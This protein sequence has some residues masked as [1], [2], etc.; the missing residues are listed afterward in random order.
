VFRCRRGRAFTVA[1]DAGLAARETPDEAERSKNEA[2][3]ASSRLEF[4]GNDE[5]LVETANRI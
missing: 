1:S 3:F 2:V 4:V 5:E